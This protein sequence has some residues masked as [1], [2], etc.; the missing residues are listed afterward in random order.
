MLRQLEVP[1]I[2]IHDLRHTVATLLF[3]QDV[4]TRVVQEVL[5]HSSIAI[6]LGTYSHVAPTVHKDAAERMEELLG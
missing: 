4:H 3:Q 2:R 1:G 6:T 5:G